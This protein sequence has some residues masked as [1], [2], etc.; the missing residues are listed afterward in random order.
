[1]FW[2]Y[3]MIIAIFPFNYLILPPSACPKIYE[4]NQQ[5]ESAEIPDPG[6]QQAVEVNGKGK[7]EVLSTTKQNV[8]KQ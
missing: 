4:G 1:M 8:V 7:G 3:K 6:A 2:K 5:L